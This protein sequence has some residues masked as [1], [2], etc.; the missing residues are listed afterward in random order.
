MPPNE[1]PDE[2]VA[3]VVRLP[4][5]HVKSLSRHILKESSFVLMLPDAASPVNDQVARVVLLLSFFLVT[6]LGGVAI[7]LLHRSLAIG[8]VA[9]TRL[10]VGISFASIIALLVGLYRILLRK[11]PKST[12][13]KSPEAPRLLEEIAFGEYE[14][15][16]KYRD[17]LALAI[18]VCMYL[19]MFVLI[20]GA[21]IGVLSNSTPT[22]VSGATGGAL[23]AGLALFIRGTMMVAHRRADEKSKQTAASYGRLAKKPTAS[24]LP[25]HSEP[26]EI[27]D[28]G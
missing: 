12:R 23:G 28:G 19:A 24:A 8:S 17:R 13:Q 15:T 4:S 2:T 22:R 20:G 21:L 7:L 25:L 18:V 5:V 14:A 1:S 11:A 16:S 26:G 27:V 9:A 6:I 3:Y 10:T